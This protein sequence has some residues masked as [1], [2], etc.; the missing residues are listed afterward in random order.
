MDPL[1]SLTK[2]SILQTGFGEVVISTTNAIITLAVRSAAFALT[3]ALLP[4]GITTFLTR[5]IFATTLV[6]FCLTVVPFSVNTGEEMFSLLILQGIDTWPTGQLLI[7]EVYAGILLGVLS[8]VSVYVALL[9]SGWLVS[10]YTEYFL[11]EAITIDEI[12]RKDISTFKPFILLLTMLIVWSSPYSSY[13]YRFF[14]TSFIEP[15]S[16]S[17][18]AP[19]IEQSFE[20]AIVVFIPFF[21]VSLVVDVCLLVADKFTTIFGSQL[22]S[23]SL[24]L[25]ICVILLSVSLLP[26][27]RELS[28]FLDKSL[29]HKS[30]STDGT[31]T[32]SSK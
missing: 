14:A 4:L 21:L 25:P 17:N 13:L 31:Q 24:K 15:I 3:F 23:A 2:L 26:Y 16:F 11:G 22:S 32:I 10:L 7:K 29:Q 27:S 20:V 9:F 1:S 8:S 12:E 28:E 19:A 6:L 30:K 18:I 5:L